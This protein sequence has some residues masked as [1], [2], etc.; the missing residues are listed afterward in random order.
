MATETIL[1]CDAGGS[2]CRG[3]VLQWRIIPPG[4]KQPRVVDLCAHHGEGVA[5]AVSHSNRAESLPSKPRRR[6][7][8]T[9]LKKEP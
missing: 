4:A 2:D 5:E 6:M 9:P 1:V 7:R 8:A 3:E